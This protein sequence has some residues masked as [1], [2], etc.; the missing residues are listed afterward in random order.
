VCPFLCPA[1]PF[2]GEDA[3]ETVC[4]RYNQQKLDRKE[5]F[6]AVRE[7]AYEIKIIDEK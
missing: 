7:L 3:E 5:I 4:I 2:H 6:L 1:A